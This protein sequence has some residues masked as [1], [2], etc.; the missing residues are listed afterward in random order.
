MKSRAFSICRGRNE[1]NFKTKTFDEL[2]SQM[3]KC[4]GF[5][6]S[7]MSSSGNIN[8]KKLTESAKLKKGPVLI[9][10]EEPRL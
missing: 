4:V 2:Q 8:L 5:Y 9:E 1:T 10:T 7:P 6:S 3:E